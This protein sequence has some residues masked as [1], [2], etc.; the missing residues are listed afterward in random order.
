M[1]QTIWKYPLQLTDVQ[2]IEMPVGADILSV[3]NQHNE[4]CLWAR[5]NPLADVAKRNRMIAIV[6]TGKPAPDPDSAEFIGTV[7][8][9]GGDL[10]W[11]VF[12]KRSAE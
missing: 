10:V 3:A 11:H 9:H 1:P 5:V 12:A 8:T 2:L 7:L 6:G 4:L